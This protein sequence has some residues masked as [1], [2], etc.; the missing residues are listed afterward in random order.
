MNKK[1]TLVLDGTELEQMQQV[2]EKSRRIRDAIMQLQ[3]A[4]SGISLEKWNE[5]AS[6]GEKYGAY[7]IAEEVLKLNLI[8]EVID[9]QGIF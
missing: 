8:D 1:I 5:L 4:R 2:M 6:A 7:L 3:C 9:S